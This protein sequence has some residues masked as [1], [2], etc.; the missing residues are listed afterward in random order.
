MNPGKMQGKT[1]LTAPQARALA[2]WWGGAHQRVP[3]PAPEGAG[4][5]HGVVL[6]RTDPD[7]AGPS[8]WCRMA[9]SSLEEAQTL[10]NIRSP[11]NPGA[12]AWVG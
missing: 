12:P 6:P 11:I 2:R 8:R 4:L 7:A 5:V 9:I 1:P 10:E 3:L